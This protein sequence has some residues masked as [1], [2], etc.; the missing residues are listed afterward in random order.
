MRRSYVSCLIV[1][2]CLNL[3]GALS[4]QSD[5]F[6]AVRNGRWSNPRTWGGQTSAAVPK[7][8]RGEEVVI[9]Q[10]VAVAL[11]LPV[12]GLASVQ[13]FGTLKVLNHVRTFGAHK[14]Q[15]NAGGRLRIGKNSSPFR[16]KIDIVLEERDSR[17]GALFVTYG[18]AIDVVGNRR[19]RS[20][21]GKLNATLAI[22][23]NS[24]EMV[25]NPGWAVGDAIV[26]ASTDYDSKQAEEFTITTVSVGASKT[27]Y[28]LNLSAAFEH[29][30]GLAGAGGNKSLTIRAE[31]ALLNR[32]VVI[33]GPLKPTVIFHG[34]QVQV[35]ALT[36]GQGPLNVANPPS[37]NIRWAEFRGLGKRL[38][39]GEYPFHFHRCGRMKKAIIEGCSFHHNYN[40][41]VVVHH[42][43]RVKLRNNVSYNTYGHAF[44]FVSG[45]EKDCELI[46][47]LGL[48]TLA[49]TA[50]REM[51]QH[52]GDAAPATFWLATMKMVVEDNISA[53]CQGTGF[54]VA[55]PQESYATQGLATGGIVNQPL[56]RSE[57]VFNR[58][59]SHSN[60]AH[61]YF[62]DD[63]P[64]L[65]GSGSPSN[66]YALVVNDFTAY[67]CEGYGLFT[68][69]LG[70]VVW[71]G[72]RT[73]DC[74]IALYAATSGYPAVD[75]EGTTV[76]KD[77]LAIGDSN[78]RGCDWKRDEVTVSR[79]LPNI[80]LSRLP[81]VFPGHDPYPD[82]ELWG[83]EIYDGLVIVD[84]AEFV[85]YMDLS[86]D[87]TGAAN[88]RIRRA[89]AIT[90]RILPIPWAID[91]RNTV[92][93]TQF[94]N[95]RKIWFRPGLESSN[96]VNQVG[97][98]DPDGS[99]S[100]PLP[101]SVSTVAEA[102]IV[103][104][105]LAMLPDGASKAGTGGVDEPHWRSEWNAW[106]VP[107]LQDRGMLQVMVIDEGNFVTTPHSFMELRREPG[108]STIVA[109]S[110]NTPP[111]YGGLLT[112]VHPFNVKQGH[113]YEMVFPKLAGSGSSG[114]APPNLES[115]SI[116]V[117]YSN[118][119]DWITFKIP[120]SNDFQPGNQLTFTDDLYFIS[121][122]RM[123][124]LQFLSSTLPP[125]GTLLPASGFFPAQRQP[126]P[127]FGLPTDSTL[128]N[129]LTVK[130]GPAPLLQDS[131]IANGSTNG[132]PPTSG[133][134][135]FHDS[136]N[137][138][139]FI[140]IVLPDYDAGSSSLIQPW[141]L[142]G[143]QTAIKP[144]YKGGM[145]TVKV[146]DR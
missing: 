21:H 51:L 7:G 124:C 96:G 33:R 53:G 73:A 16:G 138:F 94:Y 49:E 136:Q 145:I 115:F 123:D 70:Y 45:L 57:W 11:D 20:S 56:G 95:A 15:V 74:Q 102:Y 108:T 101:S 29:W 14:I 10:G 69:N 60:G 132:Q 134:A 125:L 23:A 12:T 80:N 25:G 66:P 89:A 109:R 75:G 48:S 91:P 116:T 114:G 41:T 133:L 146:R 118:P 77:V 107:K 131:T 18:G 22:G 46:G 82:G 106:I 68:R 47:N 126:D 137:D 38:K 81:N 78:N 93:N 119:G 2:F 111:P 90:N 58:N 27:T 44:F 85:N 8:G 97:I 113:L 39:T 59:L 112:K 122:L 17:T 50:P 35:G 4:A 13:I 67:K 36:R 26:V 128:V 61:G 99:I 24:L 104:D 1:V 86:L 98:Y 140:R 54:W 55:N 28:G 40:R 79:S 144:V 30:V 143:Y 34:P 117:R 110:Y 129:V 83:L 19:G 100:G 31:V 92:M 87:P 121:H 5:P 52:P 71:D 3:G 65:F 76:F 62:G 37:V 64:Y 103:A 135:W 43:E 9:Q 72:I 63:R 130:G 105:N 84:D 139:L 42:S 127:W 88:P 6:E 142:P 120:V 32:N 141:F